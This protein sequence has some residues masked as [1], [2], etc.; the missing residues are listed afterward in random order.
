MHT[1]NRLQIPEVIMREYERQNGEKMES[2][3]Q[4]GKLNL[5]R[6]VCVCVC[7]VQVCVPSLITALL[8]S[9]I[10]LWN[11]SLRL[12]R[13]KLVES[14]LQYHRIARLCMYAIS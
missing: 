12:L 10:R 5:I 13:D 6:C 2:P 9:L 7:N 8:S 11:C 1:H 4:E 14:E 3:Y